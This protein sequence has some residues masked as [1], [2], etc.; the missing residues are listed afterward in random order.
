MNFGA[1]AATGPNYDYMQV[2][3]PTDFEAADEL[4]DAPRD[5]DH[6]PEGAWDD[7][8]VPMDFSVTDAPS[9]HVPGSF[10]PDVTDTPPLQEPGSPHLAGDDGSYTVVEDAFTSHDF[11]DV[12]HPLRQH[13]ENVEMEESDDDGD[14]SYYSDAS[15]YSDDDVDIE[16]LVQILT[17]TSAA[18]VAKGA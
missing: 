11:G 14:V 18:P 2:Q 10:L 7:V 8:S 1:E 6:L 4:P 3:F 12:T 16:T 13:A 15:H 9:S 17:N 5:S